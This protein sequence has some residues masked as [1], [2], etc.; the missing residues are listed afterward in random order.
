MI[1][2]SSGSSSPATLIVVGGHSSGVGK[3]SV[4]EHILRTRRRREHWAAVK[5]SAHRH[6]T[7]ATRA[8][9]VEE[10]MWPS[11]LTQSGRYLEAGACRAFLCRAPDSRLPDATAF[12]SGL[13]AEGTSVIVESNRIARLMSPDLLL[14]VVAPSIFDWKPSSGPC[15]TRA[16]ALVTGE[17]RAAVPGAV[18]AHGASLDDRPVFEMGR[19]RRVRGLDAWLDG[20]LAAPRRPHAIA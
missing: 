12:I 3:T 16:D 18:A 4:I 15:L 9:L 17:R 1:R 20:H 2:L 6:D 11:P 7:G 13:L 8:P 14:F 5:V 10:T 19:D